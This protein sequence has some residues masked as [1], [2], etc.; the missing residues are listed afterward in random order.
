MFFDEIVSDRASFISLEGA[1]SSLPSLSGKVG[2]NHRDVDTASAI[3]LAHI[4]DQ[5]FYCSLD[6]IKCGSI[7][8]HGLCP[9]FVQKD[10]T[11]IHRCEA[12]GSIARTFDQERFIGYPRFS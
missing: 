11:S 7:S 10:G 8:Q 1:A 6:A 5:V 2:E 3:H 9:R 12:N 4:V